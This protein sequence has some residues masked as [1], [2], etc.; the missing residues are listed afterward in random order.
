MGKY[1]ISR[2]MSKV[3]YIMFTVEVIYLVDFSTLHFLLFL[4]VVIVGEGG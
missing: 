4:F 3:L 2:A 1:G